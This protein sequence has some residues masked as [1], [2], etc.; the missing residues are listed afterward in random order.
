[1]AYLEYFIDEQQ[2]EANSKRMKTR[3]GPVAGVPRA[4]A[5]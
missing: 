2:H 5:P 4:V 1:M 3:I